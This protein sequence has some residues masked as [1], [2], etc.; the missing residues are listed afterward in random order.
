MDPSLLTGI[1][2][3]CLASTTMNVGKGI[4]KMKVHVLKTGRKITAPENRKDF[5]IWL[6]GVCM[7]GAAG[8]LFTQ[9]MKMTPN[10]SVI[11]SLNGIGLIGLALFSMFVLKEKVGLREWF[12]VLM[13]ISGTALFQYFN[14][15]GEATSEY[16]MGML[17]IVLAAVTVI[18]AG[19]II[20][21]RMLN[22]GQAYVFAG[23]AGTCLG[24]MMIF[25]DMA[26]ADNTKS[27]AQIVF[28]LPFFIGFMIG[29]G[30]FLMTNLAFFHGTGIVIVPTVNS[31][32]II[33][34]MI[35][36]IFLLKVVLNP[37][38]YVGA[39]IIIVGVILIT[40]GAE[41]NGERDG[42]NEQHAGNAA[43]TA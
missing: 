17:L 43:R 14:K 22:R 3:G 13:I 28:S 21:T 8:F 23:I 5:S 32:L 6:L 26:S 30:A 36:E 31:V 24:V 34:P 40:T 19:L 9:A 18:S 11:S 4:Q 15:S 33:V 41:K 1:I 20:V 2:I 37:I 29:N 25:F 7:T 38:Q 39:A 42:T 35:M 10:P 12:A 16:T 27:F